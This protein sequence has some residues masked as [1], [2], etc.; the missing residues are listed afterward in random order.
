M[1]DHGHSAFLTPWAIQGL[2]R[3]A[4]GHELEWVYPGD[5]GPAL[6]RDAPPWPAKGSLRR[7]D[8]VIYVCL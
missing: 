5:A 7:Q 6:C 4:T 2:F 1:S 8:E 3:E